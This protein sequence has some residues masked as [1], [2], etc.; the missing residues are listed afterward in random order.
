MAVKIL[1][2]LMTL[3]E[4]RLSS[5]FLTQAHIDDRSVD[6]PPSGMSCTVAW[7]PS[8]REKASSSEGHKL[9]LAVWRRIRRKQSSRERHRG[10]GYWILETENKT[11][12]RCSN[13][14]A[15]LNHTHNAQ[16]SPW[17]ENCSEMCYGNLCCS[18]T[19]VVVHVRTLSFPFQQWLL[20]AHGA[21]KQCRL[22]QWSGLVELNGLPSQ[23]SW[24]PVQMINSALGSGLEWVLVWKKLNKIC[25]YLFVFKFWWELLPWKSP[26]RV[27]VAEA[28]P[29]T[30]EIQLWS[31]RLSSLSG[32]EQGSGHPP[33]S[34]CCPFL[35]TPL[36][37]GVNADTVHVMLLHVYIYV[38]THRALL[39]AQS[40]VTQGCESQVCHLY[41]FT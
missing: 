1:Q 3:G 17:G 35:P 10:H 33:A 21:H 32:P 26:E 30:P 31:C 12:I 15:E 19:E 18:E 41:N 36:A 7:I 11:S 28:R 34:S 14:H 24:K 16:S 5:F 2:K 29:E 6:T 23:C 13:S 25:I 38:Y 39:L 4:L 20:R 22:C 9:Q 27:C 40:N 37:T 8:Q